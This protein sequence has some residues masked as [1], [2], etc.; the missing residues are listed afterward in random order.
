VATHLLR[1]RA[2]HAQRTYVRYDSG[3]F[4]TEPG[5]IEEMNRT[6]KRLGSYDTFDPV[7]RAELT[8][9]AGRAE[10]LAGEPG[11]GGASTNS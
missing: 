3:R 2:I 6:L 7:T 5:S 4:R 8:A 11:A 10:P 9:F 1:T